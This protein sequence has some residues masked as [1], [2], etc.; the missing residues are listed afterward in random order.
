MLTTSRPG[1]Q[2]IA[3][4]MAIRRIKAGEDFWRANSLGHPNVVVYT[5]IASR[6]ATRCETLSSHLNI[7]R[8]RRSQYSSQ[9]PHL[10]NS[11]S[12]S[13]RNH[14]RRK[15]RATTRILSMPL[16]AT[17]PNSRPVRTIFVTL[18]IKTTLLLLQ[19]S[20]IKASGAIQNGRCSILRADFSDIRC[21]PDYDPVTRCHIS[22]EIC[23][24][25]DV[26]VAS[27]RVW[28]AGGARDNVTA[29]R[30]PDHQWLVS[31][32]GDH[33]LSWWRNSCGSH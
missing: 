2:T 30:S 33:R 3:S 32:S 21:V 26:A 29:R 10:T 23:K 25:E 28:S 8:L 18:A 9:R 12:D 5:R 27:K 7:D 11:P 4:T 14:M 17:V 6:T 24:Q 19:P 31:Q 1:R 13:L 16:P 20:G 22:Q 15:L